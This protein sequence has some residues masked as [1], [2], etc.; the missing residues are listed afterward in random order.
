MGR[1]CLEGGSWGGGLWYVKVLF[2]VF[3]WELGWREGRVGGYMACAFGW[4][5]A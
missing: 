3:F 1:E 4:R 2:G 5:M